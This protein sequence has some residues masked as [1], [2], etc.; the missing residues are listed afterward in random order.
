M[1]YSSVVTDEYIVDSCS[2]WS[3]GKKIDVDIGSEKFRQ[4]IFPRQTIVD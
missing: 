4:L 1:V 3:S 2:A